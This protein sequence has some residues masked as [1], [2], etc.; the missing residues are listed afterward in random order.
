MITTQW[1]DYTPVQFNVVAGFDPA[2][3]QETMQ[4][5]Q[6]WQQ[7]AGTLEM[8]SGQR[9]IVDGSDKFLNTGGI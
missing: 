3:W 7:A 6:G 4:S 9:Q 1:N 2:V 8:R 5:F